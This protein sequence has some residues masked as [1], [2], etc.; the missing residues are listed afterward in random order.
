MS[1]VE[2]VALG[3]AI[4]GSETLSDPLHLLFDSI[5]P[6]VQYSWIYVSL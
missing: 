2:D 5:V 3:L 6:T 1:K 4:L